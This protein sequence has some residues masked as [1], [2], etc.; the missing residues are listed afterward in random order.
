MELSKKGPGWNNKF[1]WNLKDTETQ[2]TD[3]NGITSQIN[4]WLTPKSQSAN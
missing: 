4:S 2:K 3:W 1:A